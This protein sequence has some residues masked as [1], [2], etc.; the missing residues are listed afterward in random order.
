MSRTRW[1]IVSI[2]WIFIATV[3]F[4]DQHAHGGPRVLVRLRPTY[5]VPTQTGNLSIRLFQDHQSQMRQ[6]KVELTEWVQHQNLRLTTAPTLIPVLGIESDQNPETL[7]RIKNHPNVEAVEIDQIIPLEEP[8]TDRT[9]TLERP[10]YALSLSSLNGNRGHGIRIAILDTGGDSQHPD[11]S[12]QGGFNAVIGSQNTYDWQDTLSICRGHGTHV[13]GIIA[14]TKTG[15]AS[16][17]SLYAVRIFENSNGNCV[18][19]SSAQ[20]SGLDWA[21]QHGAQIVN[22]SFGGGS[23]GFFGQA[24]A[25]ATSL[26][27]IIIG[28][29]GN[30]GGS[31]LF[32]ANDE[33][34]IAV[35]SIDAGNMISSFSNR[36]TEV[37][38]VAPGEGIY[39]TLPGGGYGIKSGTSMAAPQM[40]AL[41]AL[42]LQQNPK[43]TLSDLRSALAVSSLDLGPSNRDPI[44]GWGKIQPQ[45]ALELFPNGLLDPS[46]NL[47][48]LAYFQKQSLPT[49]DE[50]ILDER[51]NHN[52][53][54]DLGD[55]FLLHTR[56]G[57]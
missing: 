53:Q 23:P 48:E 18:T 42:L 15:E 14:G 22:M 39:S 55:L 33:H 36:G 40:T 52:Q 16:L 9:L 41:A 44:Y 12:F 38:V 32:P 34:V 17:A 5:Q 28:A 4:E 49:S 46:Q 25:A 35:G 54:I 56:R 7:K 21:V 45:K 10:T 20:I 13:S 26:G 1:T 37:S 30:S 2:F 11:L 51:G 50:N 57:R 29:S 43:L 47:S 8:P 3:L 27:V 31:V 24:L 19:Y 6:A